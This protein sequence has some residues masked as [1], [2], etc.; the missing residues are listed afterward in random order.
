MGRSPNRGHEIFGCAKK[1]L[2]MTLSEQENLIKYGSSINVLIT[3]FLIDGEFGVKYRDHET[4]D[5]KRAHIDLLSFT[6]E[7]AI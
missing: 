7:L 5:A 4:R 3:P 2:N 1:G 6:Y